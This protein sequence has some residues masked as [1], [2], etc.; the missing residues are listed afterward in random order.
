MLTLQYKCY[1]SRNKPG[2]SGFLPG[3]QNCTEMHQRSTELGIGTKHSSVTLKCTSCFCCQGYYSPKV[4]I[5]F[6]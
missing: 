5:K 2:S 1:R 4:V 6:M 3:R